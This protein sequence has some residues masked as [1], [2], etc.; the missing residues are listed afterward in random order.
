MEQQNKHGVKLGIFIFIGL[1]FFIVGVLA[2]GNINKTFTKTATVKTVFTEVNGLQPGDNVWFSGV[3]VGTVK[4]MRFLPNAGVEVTM[5]IESKS[6]E[7]IPKDSKAKISSDGLIGNKIIVIYG[8]NPTAGHIVDGSTFSIEETTSTEDMM[9][10][11][12]E[13]NKNVLAIT[14]DFKVISKRIADGE[15]T[16]GKF[17]TDDA[18]YENLNSTINTLKTAS[19]NTVQLTDAINDF[20]TKLNAEGGL[21]NDLATDTTV[22]NSIQKTVAQL[23]AIA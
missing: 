14:N 3:K 13:N 22:F 15:G 16:L 10:M 19:Q 11:L 8:G 2:I 12:Q 20:T 9:N 23:N 18:I 5:K 4:E 21:A 7:F 1:T 17:M 6:Q